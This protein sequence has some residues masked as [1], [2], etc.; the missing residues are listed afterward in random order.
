MT[1]Q[2]V[3]AMVLQCSLCR[4]TGTYV[5]AA[6]RLTLFTHGLMVLQFFCVHCYELDRQELGDPTF[7]D[8]LTQMGVP[9]TVVRVPMECFEHPD[10]TVPC[11]TKGHVAGMERLSL[12]VFNRVVDRELLP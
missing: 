3:D 8:R 4:E 6:T 7:A 12:E 11:I 10:A 2:M 5:V 9:T 1:E